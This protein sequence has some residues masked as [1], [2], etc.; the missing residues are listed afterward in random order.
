MQSFL[1]GSFVCLFLQNGF[2]QNFENAGLQLEP[3]S[4]HENITV[5]VYTYK[6]YKIKTI[7]TVY[8][9]CLTAKKDRKTKLIDNFTKKKTFF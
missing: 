5:D 2:F 3:L 9:Q 1:G 8:L 6:R 4:N 7:V